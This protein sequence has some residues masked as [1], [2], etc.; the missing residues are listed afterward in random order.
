MDLNSLSA[1]F[2]GDNED[3][4]KHVEE[5]ISGFKVDDLTIDWVRDFDE[6]L[7]YVCT[8]E[9]DLIIADYRLGDHDGI[10]FLAEVRKGECVKP[11]LLLADKFDREAEN[12]SYRVGAEAYLEKNIDK[13]GPLRN[14]ILMAIERS[15]AL[16]A[17]Q[18]SETRMRGIFLWSSIGIALF[19]MD[20]LIVQSNP[21]FSNIIGYTEEQLCAMDIVCDFVDPADTEPLLKKFSKVAANKWPVAKEETLFQKKDG[22]WVWVE[23]TFSAFSE[24]GT[25]PQFMIGLIEDVTEKKNAQLALEQSE[26]QL[27]R[28]S[29]DLISTQEEERRSIV[30]ELHDSIGGNLGAV[31]YLLEKLKLDHGTMDESCVNFLTQMDNLIVNTIDEVQRISTTLRPP[32]L[33]DLGIIATLKWLVREH[34][35]IYADIQATLTTSIDE[36][37]IPEPLKIVMFRITQEA[38]NNV[39]KHSKATRVEVSLTSS[40]DKTV[41]AIS[42]N[43]V[44][45]DPDILNQFEEDM[46][47]GL[48]NMT[49]RTELSNGALTITSDSGKGTTIQVE[50][51]YLTEEEQPAPS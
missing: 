13:P 15:E 42:D 32:I 3:D 35:E 10:E 24:T 39:A 18:R 34:S 19:D 51:D 6:G 30:S 22:D 7:E 47:F 27:I 28:L 41:L 21:A 33:D 11:I 17:I 8:K 43:G 1:L 9:P 14:A 23:L 49:K 50:W 20:R 48:K 26:K 44:G 46:G 5:I 12:Q 38:L 45:F 40:D 37:A 29:E 16:S 4:Y 36:D 2:V 31:K 25:R